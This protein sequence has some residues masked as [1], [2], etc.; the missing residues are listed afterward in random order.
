MQTVT[1]PTKTFEEILFRLDQLNRAVE[2]IN[3]KLESAPIYGSDEWW[4]LSEKK[5][6]EDIK[7]GRVSP[8]LHNKKE[9][10]QFL[11]SLQTS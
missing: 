7:A 4:K 3:E 9:L 1:V 5:A 10:Q 2:A 11:N 6:D 8:T